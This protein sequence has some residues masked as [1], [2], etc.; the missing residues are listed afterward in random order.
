M[1]ANVKPVSMQSTSWRDYYELCKPRVV[2][3]MVLTAIVGMCLASPG[4]IPWRIFVFGN[5]GIALA[6]CA[7]A[8]VN[9]LA[10]RHIDRV[11]KRT[12]KRPMVQGKMA[13]K[14]TITFAAVLCIVAMVML[15]V[16]VN[17]LTAILT[18]A[19]LIMYAFIYTFY[20]K[21]AT[22][23][24]IVIGGVAGAAPPMLGWV[25]VTGHVDPQSLVLLLII[26]V[27][28]PPHFWALA[29]NRI[30]DYAKAGVPMLPNTHGIPYTK[31]HVWYYTILLS[32]VTLLPFA[33]K[34]SSWI[35]LV[36]VIVLTARFLQ[37][38]WRLKKSD[39]AKT[40]MAVF[41]YSITYL[42]LLFVALLVDHYV[43][44]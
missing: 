10:D 31:Q 15:T 8:A 23:Q 12:M 19:S 38:A 28:T 40:P 6:A 24:N 35:Y 20:L 2:M 32:L 13:P 22:P 14:H 44:F 9:H 17:G 37:W 39:D 18:F 34:M 1:N 27:W 29:I 3:L 36:S 11:M 43:R 42:M 30:E 16:F 7:A 33:I 4:A 26:F 21:H 41:K 5:L 25:A